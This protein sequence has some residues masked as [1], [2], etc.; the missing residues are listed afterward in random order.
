MAARTHE[1]NLLVFGKTGEGS[2][3][4]GLRD[5]MVV[6]ILVRERGTGH[7]RLGQGG[8]KKAVERTLEGWNVAMGGPCSLVR[9]DALKGVWGMVN[10]REAVRLHA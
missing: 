2:G 8:R 6:E 1:V 7:E 3:G 9:L 10:V 4:G 5:E